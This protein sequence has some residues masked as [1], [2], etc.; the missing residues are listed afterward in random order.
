VRARL[1]AA[2]LSLAIVGH[3]RS[4]S[5]TFLTAT[6]AGRYD[7]IDLFARLFL[8]NVRVAPRGGCIALPSPIDGEMHWREWVVEPSGDL[9]PMGLVVA[10]TLAA[11][12]L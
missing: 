11:V 9:P 8:R 5:W 7:D 1:A 6:H 3:P 4:K 10:A 2:D 12:K